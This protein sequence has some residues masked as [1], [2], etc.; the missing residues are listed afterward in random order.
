MSLIF[1]TD[2]AGTHDRY[3]YPIFINERGEFHKGEVNCSEKHSCQ[4]VA[5][6][7]GLRSQDSSSNILSTKPL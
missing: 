5:M 7:M 2:F 1:T 3:D 6:G 4:G